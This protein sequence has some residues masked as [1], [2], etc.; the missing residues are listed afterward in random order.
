MNFLYIVF[1]G[2]F[3]HISTAW[4]DEGSSVWQDKSQLKFSGFGTLGISHLSNKNVDF[5]TNVQ[6]TGPGRTRDV[7]F[8]LDSRL[9]VQLDYDFD[10][11]TTATIQ[12][13][14]ERNAD[15][16]FTPYISLLNLR[17]EFDNGLL[18]RAGRIQPT[19]YMATEYR[20]ANF[21]NPWVRPPVTVYG[22]IPLTALEAVDVSYPYVT[23]YGVFTG[24]LGVNQFDF[25]SARSNASGTD[26][27]KGKNGRNIGIKWQQGAWLAK[28]GWSIYDVTYES[29]SIKAALAGLSLFDPAAANAL[30]LNN[31][32]LEIFSAGLTYEGQDWLMMAEWAER[33]SD[34]ILPTA[35][36]AYVTIGRQFGKTLPYVTIGRR[37]TDNLSVT[38]NNPIA[39]QII[40]Q[41]FSFLNYSQWTASLGVSYPIL[42]KA[43][44]KFQID[45]IK[46]DKGS[47]GPYTNH[48][49]SY[50]ST[51]PPTDVL[52]SVNLDFVF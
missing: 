12:A 13:V 47:F 1:A 50:D 27:V 16:T 8:G 30:A 41:I 38:S 48:S 37:E 33:K 10:E 20:L 17:H 22:L 29:P 15:K 39:S 5:A 52:I 35:R 11:D 40:N 9:G 43:N 34:A 51:H 32:P 28:I 44:L 45:W 31:T 4:A 25:D 36:G 19:T 42:E 46:P 26:N 21:P 3:L 6:P 24:W 7:D 2:M 49:T 14:S 23:D 18:I